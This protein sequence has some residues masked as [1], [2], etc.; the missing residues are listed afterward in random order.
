MC[1][2][3]C[4]KPVEQEGIREGAGALRRQF[5][6][7]CT[8]GVEKPVKAGMFTSPPLT[9]GGGRKGGAL[10]DA[11]RFP[12]LGL[13]WIVQIKYKKGAAI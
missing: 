8:R 10:Q 9:R 5:L 13:E 12:H 4:E 11:L 7:E 3:E 1:I 6:G 2:D